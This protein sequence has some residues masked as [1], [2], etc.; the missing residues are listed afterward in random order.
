MAYKSF[1]WRKGTPC[2][3]R[4]KPATRVTIRGQSAYT[5]YLDDF[6]GE[7]V[8]RVAA[9]LDQSVERVL[10]ARNTHLTREQ[11]EREL[12]LEVRQ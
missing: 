2:R 3:L 7:Q 6:M 10:V 11:I 4:R 8:E 12:E 5:R 9:R 1:G